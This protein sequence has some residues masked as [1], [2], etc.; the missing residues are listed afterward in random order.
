[1]PKRLRSTQKSRWNELP[2]RKV[3]ATDIEMPD[4]DEGDYVDNNFFCIEE[5]DG[6]YVQDLLKAKNSNPES[7]VEFK[8]KYADSTAV[9]GAVAA[10]EDSVVVKHSKKKAK[11]KKAKSDVEEKKTQEA[12]KAIEMHVEACNTLVV[13]AKWGEN[14]SI[15]A[16][17]VNALSALHFQLPTPIQTKAIP[18]TLAGSI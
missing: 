10:S 4:T 2:W 1:M 12:D 7:T 11:V 9:S 15:H 3:S 6:K 5:V 13:D 8:S 16:S 17:L 14:I 18:V